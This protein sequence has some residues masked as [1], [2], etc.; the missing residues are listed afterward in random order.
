MQIRDMT[1]QDLEAYWLMVDAF[2]H[3]DHLMF[4]QERETFEKNARRAMEGDDRLRMCVIEQ[5]GQI[6]GYVILTLYWSCEV[7]GDVVLLDEI[8]IQPA[9]RGLGLGTRV[10]EWMVKTYAGRAV[11]AKLETS[12]ENDRA[13]ALYTRMGFAPVRY[14][15]MYRL[16]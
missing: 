14:S 12:P 6:A 16:L 1:P 2:Y 15:T 13:R 11:C 10:I 9:Y 8:F 3:E 7:G 4:A 5:E